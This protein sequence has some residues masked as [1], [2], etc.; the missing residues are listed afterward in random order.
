VIEASS[1]GL[2]SPG[3][4]PPEGLDVESALAVA[5]RHDK[6][7]SMRNGS[8][9]LFA[10][11]IFIL[12]A[13]TELYPADKN[14]LEPSRSIIRIVTQIQKADYEGDRPALKRLHDDLTPI[15]EDNK[16]ASRVRD[17]GDVIFI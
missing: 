15:P 13:A 8:A 2:P 11:T 17:S 10:L 1:L 5:L 16:L 12:S 3:R 14:S 4:N 9:F 7:E 6:E